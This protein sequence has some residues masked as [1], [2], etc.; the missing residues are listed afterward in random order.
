MKKGCDL[1]TASTGVT[2]AILHAEQ[3]VA[4]TQTYRDAWREVADW[5]QRIVELTEPDSVEGAIARRGV[6]SALAKSTG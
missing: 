1:E 4:G 5:E 2:G 3:Q 6:T